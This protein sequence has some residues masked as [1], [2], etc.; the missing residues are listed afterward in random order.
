MRVIKR[1]KSPMPQYRSICE[2][3]M[4]LEVFVLG[5]IA[6][7]EETEFKWLGINLATRKN[8]V[9]H[10]TDNFKGMEVFNQSFVWLKKHG[11]LKWVVWRNKYTA[12]RHK[13]SPKGNGREVTTSAKRTSPIAQMLFPECKGATFKLLMAGNSCRPAEARCWVVQAIWV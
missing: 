9:T 13:I 6:T 7:N 5:C 3:D 12:T 2:E 10:T 4:N 1:L 8:P 11:S